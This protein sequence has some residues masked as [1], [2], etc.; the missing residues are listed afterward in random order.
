ME[1]LQ[2]RHKRIR[3]IILIAT[4]ITAV[5]TPL[6]YLAAAH[7][8]PLEQNGSPPIN[9]VSGRW[10]LTHVLVEGCPCSRSIAEHLLSRGRST[11]AEE[12]VV[13]AAAGH[14]QPWV[15]ALRNA[16]YVVER[17]SD[18]DVAAETGV[19]GGPWLLIFDS[20]GRSRYAGGYLD[21]RPG[22]RGQRQSPADLDILSQLRSG[23][24]VEPLRAL[25]CS[26]GQSLS[27]PFG[28]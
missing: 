8:K 12:H 27:T 13:I 26:V 22:A 1:A 21:G 16:G 5:S 15:D 3:P 10:Q 25:G 23:K 7:Q 4:W 14:Q 6:V 2:H 19:T 18:S 9:A 20:Q 24:T 11:D 17:K 28:N